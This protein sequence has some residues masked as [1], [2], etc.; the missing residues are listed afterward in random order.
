[1]SDDTAGAYGWVNNAR[2][3]YRKNPDLF[4][5]IGAVINLLHNEGKKY[6]VS[7]EGDVRAA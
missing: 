3:R 1:M 2:M 6:K 4:S 7:P 5:I